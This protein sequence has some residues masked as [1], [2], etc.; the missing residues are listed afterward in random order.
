MLSWIPLAHRAPIYQRVLELKEKTLQLNA[1]D[2]S[3]NM[4]SKIYYPGKFVGS[5]ISPAPNS[6]L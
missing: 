5:S 1:M 4:P 3:V 2:W 6:T